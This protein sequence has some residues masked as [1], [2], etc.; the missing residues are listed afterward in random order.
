MRAFFNTEEEKDI[1]NIVK[2]LKERSASDGD[3]EETGGLGVR[4]EQNAED[5]WEFCIY[6]VIAHTTDKK[7]RE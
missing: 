2:S 3:Y 6:R 5:Y 4:V 7:V 1:K